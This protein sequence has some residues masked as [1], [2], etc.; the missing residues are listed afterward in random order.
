MDSR[1]VFW[2]FWLNLF[3]AWATMRGLRAGTVTEGNPLLGRL[4]LVSPLLAWSV[5][6]VALPL[7]LGLVSAAHPG[8]RWVER[9]LWVAVAVYGAVSLLHLAHLFA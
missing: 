8:H 1:P 4:L 3:D 9:S 5:K 7:V 6:L 2:L